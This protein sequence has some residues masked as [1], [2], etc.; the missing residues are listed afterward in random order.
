MCV[1]PDVFAVFPNFML[2]YNFV[3]FFEGFSGLLAAFIER[4]AQYHAFSD[5]GLL[6]FDVVDKS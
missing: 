2:A 3:E 6:S 5:D 4:T 1:V